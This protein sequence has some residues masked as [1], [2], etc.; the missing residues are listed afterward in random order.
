[1]VARSSQRAF[2]C[3]ECQLKRIRSP[4]NHTI[5]ARIPRQSFCSSGPRFVPGDS[6][7]IQLQQK[8]R[9]PADVRKPRV[10]G[11]PQPRLIRLRRLRGK[12]GKEFSENS[13]S[14]AVQS[15]GK[16]AEVIIIRDAKLNK[17]PPE[18]EEEHELENTE[19]NAEESKRI[20]GEIIASLK[21]GQVEVS[22]D[23]VNEQINKLWPVQALPNQPGALLTK[24][25]YDRVATLL[26]DRFTTVQLL[27]Y[28]LPLT[29]KLKSPK[30]KDWPIGWSFWRSSSQS[31]ASVKNFDPKYA[32]SVPKAKPKLIRF[33]VEALWKVETA[34]QAELAGQIT[35]T[36]KTGDLMLLTSGSRSNIFLTNCL[37]LTPFQHH[38][39]SML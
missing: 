7:S 35:G 29:K 17:N 36:L 13:V 1:M 23:I 37:Q 33:I 12:D 9:E 20:S 4:S 31:P 14:L 10:H 30:E 18:Q 15:L 16:P 21:D 8:T 5:R 26:R 32:R 6:A 25:E 39:V 27:R 19:D 28:A 11:T 38:L 2:V 34:G 24:S 3:F 22:Q